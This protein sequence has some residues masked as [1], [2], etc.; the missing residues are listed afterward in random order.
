MEDII[1]EDLSSNPKRFWAYVKS[2]GQE[3]AGVS[4]LQDKDGFL[5]SDSVSKV[6]ILNHQFKSVF[7]KEDTT[8]IPNKGKRCQI[9]VTEAGVHKLLQILRPDKA[10]GPD[11]IPAFLLKTVQKS[12]LQY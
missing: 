8:N 6:E 3:S 1:S 11:S 5:K 9:S 7:I 12:L 10:T 2:K 4:P